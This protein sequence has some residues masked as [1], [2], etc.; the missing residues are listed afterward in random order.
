MMRADLFIRGQCY[1]IHDWNEEKS[2]EDEE[3]IPPDLCPHLLTHSILNVIIIYPGRKE[4]FLPSDCKNGTFWKDMVKLMFIA[5]MKKILPLFC[6]GNPKS[7]GIKLG[8]L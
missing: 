1:E 8:I 2:H 3:Y 4:R 7:N 6:S 5:S